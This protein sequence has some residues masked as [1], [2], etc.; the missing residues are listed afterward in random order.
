[1]RS[2]LIVFF[3]MGIS[4]CMV[5]LESTVHPTQGELEAFSSAVAHIEDEDVVIEKYYE[6]FGEPPTDAFGEDPVLSMDAFAAD[7]YPGHCAGTTIEYDIS[8]QTGTIYK[9]GTDA[10]IEVRFSGT[11]NG[12]TTWT[13]WIHLDNPGRDD[14]ERGQLDSFYVNQLSKGMLGQ[15]QV[16]HN[17]AGDSPAWYCDWIEIYDPCSGWLWHATVSRWLRRSDGLSTTRHLTRF[18]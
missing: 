15:I 1:M 2:A 7:A 16:R 10:K 3:V 8:V 17:N 13:P 6:F 11:Y 14:F 5:D 18:N 9:S 4:G 12:S